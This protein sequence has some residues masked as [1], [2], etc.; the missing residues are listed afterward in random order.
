MR[1]KWFQIH[2]I[3]RGKSLGSRVYI[4]G[5]QLNLL[6]T[7]N[8]YKSESV[9]LKFD[10]E[11]SYVGNFLVQTNVF[12]N[13]EFVTLLQCLRFAVQVALAGIGDKSHVVPNFR[14]SGRII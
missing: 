14:Y 9:T 2:F 5:K 4:V 3:N 7:C 12:H 6:K 8:H 10:D 11:K 1:R 13:N